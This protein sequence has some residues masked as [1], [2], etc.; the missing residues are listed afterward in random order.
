MSERVGLGAASWKRLELEDRAPKG[1][2]L[3]QLVEMGVS[4]DWLLTGVG[5]M[6]RDA[7]AAPAAP[8]GPIDEQL[9][10]ETLRL[11]EDWLAAHRRTMAPARK[12]EVAASIYAMAVEDA[13]AGKPAVD[14]R[15]VAQILKL[16]G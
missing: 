2:V 7:P 8:P 4:A 14:Q 5:Q 12:A 15:R 13:A 3:A 16:V 1:E 9:L 6:R 11:V 10:A